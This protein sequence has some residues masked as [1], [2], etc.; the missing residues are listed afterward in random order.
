MSFALGVFLGLVRNRPHGRADSQQLPAR[1][2]QTI[3]GTEETVGS[4]LL[5]PAVGDDVRALRA[6]LKVSQAV[7]VPA[8]STMHSR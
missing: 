8:A 7:L 1:G 3:G 4:H 5:E 6:V 2:E